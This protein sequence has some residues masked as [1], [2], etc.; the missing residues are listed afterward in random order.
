MA[1]LAIN[2]QTGEALYQS[3][4]GKWKPA[5]IAENEAGQKA[6][7]NGNE[8]EVIDRRSEIKQNEAQDEK[9]VLEAASDYVEGIANE[10]SNTMSFGMSNK[11]SDA[12]G[13]MGNQFGNWLA[14]LMQGS[15]QQA[16]PYKSTSEKREE[17][18]KSNPYS[19]TVASIAGSMANPIGMKAGKWMGEGATLGSQTLRGA[20]GGAG[21]AGAQALGESEGNLSDRLMSGLKAG[22]TGGL[23]GGV[24][25]AI[26]KLI[27]SGFTGAMNQASRFSG[28][29][30]EKMSARKM[31][32]AIKRDGFTMEQAQARMKEI[33]P[34]ATLA[35]IGENTRKL[36]YS[37]YARPGEGSGAVKDFFT[38]RQRGD[39]GEDDLLHGGQADRIH[40]WLEKQFPAKYQ[41]KANDVQAGKLYKNAYS[42]NQSVQSDELDLILRTPDGKKAFADAVRMMQNSREFVGRQ[43]P[44]LT[45]LLK[46]VEGVSTG[47]GVSDGLKLKTWDYVKRAMQQTEKQL[48]KQDR[49]D[50]A[51]IINQNIKKLTSE[52]D[53]ID[54]GTTGGAY[55]KARSLTSDDFKNVDAMELGQ[56]FMFKNMRSSDIQKMVSEMSPAEQH[57][58]RIGAVDSLT[59]KLSDTISGANATKTGLDIASLQRKIKSIFGDD[60][61]FAKYMQM[62]KGEKQMFDTYGMMGGSQT[63]RNISALDDANVDPNMILQGIQT[64]FKGGNPTGGVLQV[65]G[66]LKDRVTL[67]PD[68]SRELANLLT[69]NKTATL[70][71]YFSPP[72]LDQGKFAELLTRASAGPVGTNYAQ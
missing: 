36:M 9:G 47:V 8:W 2:E 63:A 70:Q 4:S 17:F 62:L 16:I 44:E 26:M 13:E 57:H 30:Q 56:K 67:P 65:L 54:Q 14:D 3:E 6:F 15:K 59:N 53:R 1:K 24:S 28:P 69:G 19:S 61:V 10:A 68:M 49:T 71:K 60:Q 5:N 37:V 40:K 48:I 22:A 41:G 64:T 42:S 25:P 34:D 31:V 18:Q 23:V 39:F 33:G 35:D 11:I 7:F 50:E 29:L 72:I 12:G 27:S 55:A 46:D 38:K 21:L 32:E 43:N 66:G 52:L 58:F 45:A 20:A 51:R